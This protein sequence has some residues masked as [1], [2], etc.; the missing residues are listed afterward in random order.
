MN[1]HDHANPTHSAVCDVEGCG[2]VA[3]THAHNDESAFLD[4]SDALA[5]HNLEVHGIETDPQDIVGDVS[6]KTKKLS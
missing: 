6:A 5:Q 4:L 1:N 2:F 3:E